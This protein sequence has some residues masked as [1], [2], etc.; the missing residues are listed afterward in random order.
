MRLQAFGGIA[1]STLALSGCLQVL[2]LDKYTEGQGGNGAG[3]GGVGGAGNGSTS[4]SSTSGAGPSGSK[5]SSGVGGM[6]PLHE[7][8]TVLDAA[9]APQAGLT[10]FAANPDG[11]PD[12]VK[13]TDSLGQ[14]TLDIPA[15]GSVS[16]ADP[17]ALRVVTY[18]GVSKGASV[19]FIRAPVRKNE[20]PVKLMQII[21]PSST[22]SVIEYGQSCD[23]FT[24][25]LSGNGATSNTYITGCPN[26]ATLDIVA[27]GLGPGTNGAV[28]SVGTKLGIA[29]GSGNIG[30]IAQSTATSG[31]AR[32][33]ATIPGGAASSTFRITGRRGRIPNYHR[34]LPSANAGPLEMPNA[35]DGYD[36]EQRIVFAKSGNSTRVLRHLEHALTLPGLT[37]VT[38]PTAPIDPAVVAQAPD[39]ATG[40]LPFALTGAAYADAIVLDVEPTCVAF[41]CSPTWTV[42]SPP[43]AS[44]ML[45]LPVLPAGFESLKP[46]APFTFTTRHVDD[47]T[48]ADFASLLAAGW[49]FDDETLTESRLVR[50]Y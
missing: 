31:S 12:A 35:F 16:L 33:I 15:G 26:Q 13:Q 50:T 10:V 46:L 25:P 22:A 2:G 19:R 21:N 8:I 39:L 30:T 45:T 44:G 48:A 5:S 36:F 27:V 32:G 23:I 47:Q 41:L 37:N 6:G 34:E 9:S 40:K 14:V 24:L 4:M 17:D 1:L 7:T 3:A 38:M 18:F 29:Y 11:T 43:V 49:Q 42:V 28:L 20:N